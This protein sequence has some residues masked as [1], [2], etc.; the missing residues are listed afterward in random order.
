MLPLPPTF[1]VILAK[2]LHKKFMY[3]YFRR[4][5]LKGL[6]DKPKSLSLSQHEIQALLIAESRSMEQK[7]I[8]MKPQQKSWRAIIRDED[9]TFSQSE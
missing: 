8:H 4:H 1:I 6:I 9:P 7:V 2:T 5:Q 3:C